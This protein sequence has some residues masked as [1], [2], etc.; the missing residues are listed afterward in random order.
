[1]SLT[2]F[3]VCLVIGSSEETFVT[4]GA[5]VDV[6][7]AIEVFDTDFL[8]SK[9]RPLQFERLL[10]KLTR[11]QLREPRKLEKKKQIK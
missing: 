9:L 10:T 1:M 2:F 4:F 3:D 11:E 6:R 5:G 7:L 8:M